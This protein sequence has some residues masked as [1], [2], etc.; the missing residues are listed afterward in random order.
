MKKGTIKYPR[1]HYCRSRRTRSGGTDWKCA[2]CG[3]KWVKIRNPMKSPNHGAQCPD[4]KSKKIIS[5]GLSW[6]CKDCGRQW[7]KHLH[8]K[9]E[10][11][12]PD[13]VCPQCGSHRVHSEGFDWRCNNCSRNFRKSYLKSTKSI[14]LVS[15]K[16]SIGVAL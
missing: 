16:Q 13:I 10:V 4:C 9:K 1:C 7:L 11:I 15:V 3:R 5:H 2:K 12:Q 8:P 6:W 14:Y